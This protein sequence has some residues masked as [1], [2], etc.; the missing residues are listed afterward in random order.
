M[1][2]DEQT[3]NIDQRAEAFADFC[4]DTK[5]CFAQSERL[6]DL[7]QKLV[8]LA[9]VS[10]RRRRQK[11]QRRRHVVRLGRVDV[12]RVG[13]VLQKKLALSG[14][15]SIRLLSTLKSTRLLA[16]QSTRLKF[17][18]CNLSYMA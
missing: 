9:D 10:L 14:D 2:R 3:F 8:D 1:K 18:K 6:L 11:L 13:D 7:V 12:T 15:M 5:V 4:P 17:A 16:K